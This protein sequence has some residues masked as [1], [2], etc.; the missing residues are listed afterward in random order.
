MALQSDS[1]G[2]L[3]GDPIDLKR[4]PND[5]DHIRDDVS[6]IRRSIS[7]RWRDYSRADRAP[8]PN[9]VMPERGANGRFVSSASP[10]VATPTARKGDSAIA[11]RF[12][13]SAKTVIALPVAR[14]AGAVSGIAAR[15][16]SADPSVK[17]MREVAEPLQRGFEFF[18]GDKQT[19]WLKKIFKSLNIFHKEDTVYNKAAKKSLKAIEEKSVMAGGSYGSGSLVDKIP[20]LATIAKTGIG[21]GLLGLLTKAGRGARGLFKRI[22]VIGSLLAGAGA[23]FDIYG[24]END[25]TMTRA[26]KDAAAGKS[27][28]G[29]AGSLA[30]IG[31]GAMAG[32]VAGPIGTIVG[33]VVGGF[34]GDQAGQVI[35]EKFG[36]WVN[37]L[38]KA[39]IPGKITAAWD[40]AVEKFSA[41]WDQVKGIAGKAVDVAKEQIGDANAYLK[42][43]SGIDLKDMAGKWLDRTQSNIGGMVD[44]VKSGFDWLGKN[45]TVGKAIATFQGG[46]IPGL[47]NAQAAALA[48]DTRRT[49]SSGNYAAENKFGYIGSYQFGAAALADTG[50]IDSAKLK[51]AKKQGRFNQKAFLADP[52]NWLIAGGKDA[53]LSDQALQDQ[54]YS[55]YSA[56]LQKAGI[57]AGVL[58]ADSSPEQVAAYIKAAHLVGAGGA[59][60]YFVRWIDGSDANGTLASKY[61]SQG[62]LA[63]ASAPKISRPPGPPSMPPIAEA[64][65]VVEPLS[66]PSTPQFTVNIPSQDVGQRLSDRTTAYI[67]SGG[68]HK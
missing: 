59:N 65:K 25:P 26:Q 44:G 49:E 40:S 18:R 3:V 57:R 47:S 11:A 61:A 12:A 45:T 67:A 68:I 53:F 46:T 4:M 50:L 6:A 38:R 42:K 32:S 43:Q 35:G 34:L 55:K 30:G 15:L 19:S 66:S 33:G 64:P 2:F 5:I 8:R 13:S 17:A 54:T 52:S 22:P 56:Q 24:S 23:A 10:A 39:D 37:D 27:V 21:G 28:G 16:E 9:A 41:A 60:N 29:W 20:G 1:R 31:A 58:S 48:A 36:E 14:S 7:E 62:A 51:A 63:V